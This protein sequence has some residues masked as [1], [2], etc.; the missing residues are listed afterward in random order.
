MK[1]GKNN[2]TTK[3][4]ETARM[5]NGHALCTNVVYYEIHAAV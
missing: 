2:I 3:Y 1:I 4:R 5:S